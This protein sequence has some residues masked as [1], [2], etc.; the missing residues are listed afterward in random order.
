MYIQNNVLKHAL[1]NVLF[2]SGNACGGKTTLSRLLAQ[3]YGFTLYDMDAQYALHRAIADDLHQ[4]ETCYHM[5]DFHQQ[6]TRPIEEQA[7][8]SMKSIEEQTDMVLIDL[9][10]LSEHQKVVADVLFSPVYTPA[11]LNERQIVFLTVHRSEIRRSYFN[12]PEKRSFFDFVRK[13]PL[14]DLYFE[15]IFQSL[16]LTNDREQALMRQTG[17]LM[18]ERRPDESPEARLLKIER[19]FGL[20]E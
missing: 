11:L 3:K 14:A 5:K 10:R 1:K 18:L 2:L 4:P 20:I 19:H 15:N 7:R 6:W 8:W 9:I 16:E 17:F 13:Q 12:R